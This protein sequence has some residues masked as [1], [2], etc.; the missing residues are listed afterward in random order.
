MEASTMTLDQAIELVR[1]EVMVVN[2]KLGDDSMSKSPH[3]GYALVLEE[4]D[5]VWDE[6]RR[7]NVGLSIKEM[8][9]VAATATRYV[10]QMSNLKKHEMKKLK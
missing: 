3:K 7:N 2:D 6:I 8:I 4:L 5:E 9:Q 1:V 10:H